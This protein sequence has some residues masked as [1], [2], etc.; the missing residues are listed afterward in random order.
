MSY[1]FNKSLSIFLILVLGLS[2]MSSLLASVELPSDQDPMPCHIPVESPDLNLI[3]LPV[4]QDCDECE[5]ASTC[6][7]HCASH[8]VA[9]LPGFSTFHG[10]TAELSLSQAATELVT[11]LPPALYR[12]P[13]SWSEISSRLIVTACNF[14]LIFKSEYVPGIP[15]QLVNAGYFL[16]ECRIFLGLQ[17]W[18]QHRLKTSRYALGLCAHWG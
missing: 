3:S 11:L 7:S 15:H 2:P 8:A 12:P 18:M 5:T 13:R 17:Q 14:Q 4:M 6:N 1:L 16:N 9:L 10:F